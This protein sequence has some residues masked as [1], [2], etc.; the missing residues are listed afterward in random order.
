LDD[1]VTEERRSILEAIAAA[2]D[3]R[4]RLL[5]D[6]RANPSEE[7][8]NAHIFLQ[9]HIED[10]TREYLDLITYRG[11]SR[12]P[13]T[14]IVA[15]YPIDDFGLDGLFWRFD[16]P[17]RPLSDLPPTLFALTGAVDVDELVEAAPFLVKP[18]PG[19]PYVLPRLL[20]DEQ[21]TAV[22]SS[23][24]IGR[25][26]A[27]CIA[28]YASRPLDTFSAA[29]EWG[30]D[31]WTLRYPQGAAATLAMLELETERDYDLAPWIESGRLSWIA[32]GDDTL[33]LRTGTDDCP[34]LEA[35]GRRS[36][37]L[38]EDGIVR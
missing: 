14:G 16:A 29:A 30:T 9:T 31:E 25:H 12:C 2:E 18:G 32:P 23:L 21:A 36:E 11:I 7:L 4:L 28:Y 26:Q 6:Y 13:H 20:V 17:V 24:S 1:Q 33:T 37:I 5:A 35:G 27:Y 22:V 10:L 8:T 19:A 34:Y 38:I 15:I 3:G